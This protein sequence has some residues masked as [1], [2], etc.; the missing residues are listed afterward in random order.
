MSNI[1]VGAQYWAYGPAGKAN[2]VSSE[3]NK[4]G[5][6][7]DFVGIETAYDLCSDTDYF[8]KLYNFDESNFNKIE[9]D[10]DV[11]V[12]VMNPH[13]AMWAYKHDFPLVYIDS[14]SWFWRWDELDS[15]S[16]RK[17]ISKIEKVD[18]S[19]ACNILDKLEP[20]EQQL[21]AHIVSDKILAQGEPQL[22]KETKDKAKNVGSII[23]LDYIDKSVERDTL[24]VS[25]SGGLSPATDLSAAMR[26]ANLVLDMLGERIK[27]WPNAQRFVITGHPLVISNLDNYPDFFELESYSHSEF[28]TAL[29]RATCVL[30]PCGFT[31]IYESLAYGAPLAFLPENHNGHV[32]EYLTI[33]KGIEKLK[34]KEKI[35]PHVLFCLDDADLDNIMPIDESMELIKNYTQKYLNSNNFRELY[36]S[37]VGSWIGYFKDSRKIY[38]KQKEQ[39]LTTIPA[40]S[41]ASNVAKEVK[42]LIAST[43]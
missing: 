14:M 41:G 19:E 26:Y 8:N 27:N 12:S 16:V 25:L 17:N 21:F 23:N 13:L 2:A 5:Y 24:L 34:E 4:E 7:L 6:D 40:F 29:N 36:R 10:Y 39:I 11:V 33:T 28:L 22:V 3:L 43:K 31:T 9:K 35:F 38:Q 42:S 15:D 20:D 37:K 30:V 18:F 1:L 32:Y